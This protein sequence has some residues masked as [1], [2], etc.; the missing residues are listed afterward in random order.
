MAEPAPPVIPAALHAKFAGAPPKQSD[1]EKISQSISPRP[2][3]FIE[4]VIKNP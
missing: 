3:I 2:T 4:A 1:S